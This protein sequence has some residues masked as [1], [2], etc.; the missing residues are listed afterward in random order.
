MNTQ[1]NDYIN[2]PS[3]A[4]KTNSIHIYIRPVLAS[5]YSTRLSDLNRL[6]T[7]DYLTVTTARAALILLMHLTDYKNILV[8]EAANL[9]GISPPTVRIIFKSLLDKG[10]I[11]VKTTH[12][13][14]NIGALVPLT[15]YLITIE[16]RKKV[17]E[18]YEMIGNKAVKLK[19]SPFL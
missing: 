10:F 12:R 16:G 7:M 15:G 9:F 8:T 18:F 6:L 5:M 4:K 19:N 11:R 14:T 2:R 13:Q 1:P 3:Q 17:N